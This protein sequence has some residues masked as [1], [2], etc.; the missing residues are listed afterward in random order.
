M[1]VECRSSP[2]QES[3]DRSEFGRRVGRLLGGDERLATAGSR[4]LAVNPQSPLTSTRNARISHKK[5][6]N[7]RK[8]EYKTVDDDG[9]ETRKCREEQTAGTAAGC[10]FSS[11]MARLKLVGEA[12]AR[13][14]PIRLARGFFGGP[15]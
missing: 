10:P 13:A 7:F 12:V 4:L 6:Y 3:P 15:P 11:P 1:N 9:R 5:K 14:M 2:S 8:G